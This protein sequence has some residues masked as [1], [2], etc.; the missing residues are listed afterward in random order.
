MR[1]AG[2][3]GS[4]GKEGVSECAYECEYMCKSVC[5]CVWNGEGKMAFT[6]GGED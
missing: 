5:V 3:Q 2:D 6:E 1:E 4:E